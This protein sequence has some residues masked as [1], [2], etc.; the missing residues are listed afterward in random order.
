MESEGA[1]QKEREAEPHRRG[2]MSKMTERKR[3]RE[4]GSGDVAVEEYPLLSL[5]PILAQCVHALFER[6]VCARQTERKRRS[7]EGEGAESVGGEKGE[8]RKIEDHRGGGGGGGGR[9]GGGESIGNSCSALI[10]RA[11][12]GEGDRERSPHFR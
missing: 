12:T 9:G 6:S 1:R 4:V 8:G 3:E 10:G 7:L 11:H 2:S 5:M